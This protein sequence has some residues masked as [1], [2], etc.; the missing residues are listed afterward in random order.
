MKHMPLAVGLAVLTIAAYLTIG[1]Q[2]LVAGIMTVLTV[3][4]FTVPAVFAIDFALSV[5]AP[6]LDEVMERNRFVAYAVPIAA[7][8]GALA[9][10]IGLAILFTG[11]P[12][13]SS[14]NPNETDRPG[15]GPF[16]W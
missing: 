16:E 3:L 1:F 2:G 7:D 11:S 8:L 6:D 12:T 10:G 14:D 9:I 4:F 15:V 13:P 5:I